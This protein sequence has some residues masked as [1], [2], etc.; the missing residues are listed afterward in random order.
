MDRLAGIGGISSGTPLPPDVPR[1][2]PSPRPGCPP[3]C[4]CRP[5][6][7]M[8]LMTST[9]ALENELSGPNDADCRFMREL[10]GDVLVLGAG[11]KMG[12]SLALR[13]RRA[14]DQAGLPRRILAASRFANEETRNLLTAGGVEVIACDFLE[15]VQ[16]S[17]LPLCPN[18]L[19]LVGRKFGST[20][21]LPLTWA[22][23]TLAPAFVAE[24]FKASRIVAVS[25]G[26]IY[27]LAAAAC[28]ENVPPAPVGEYAQSVLGRERLL[29][30]FSHRYRTEMAI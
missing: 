22:T 3:V 23:N 25:S 19:F 5:R 10:E 7:W 17:S 15:R 9:S 14:A 24:K 20:E 18:I 4:D 2:N 26:N 6:I 28:A 30:Y 11:G 12:P 21:N 13:A 1:P 16:I 27:P 8:K 29:E